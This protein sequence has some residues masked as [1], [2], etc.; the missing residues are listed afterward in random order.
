MSIGDN[1][2]IYK[3]M[4]GW[5]LACDPFSSTTMICSRILL[6][7]ALCSLLASSA[8]SEAPESATSSGKDKRILILGGGVGVHFP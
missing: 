3:L 1:A 4:L 7:A 8:A 2:A 5:V 6:L